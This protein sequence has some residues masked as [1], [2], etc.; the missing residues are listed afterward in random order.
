MQAGGVAG[1]IHHFIRF[2]GAGAT[3]AVIRQLHH[4]ICEL[5]GISPPKRGPP[6][7]QALQTIP[8]NSRG[9]ADD[10]R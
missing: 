3:K 10:E 7:Q 4:D 9:N 6:A 1:I 5:P 2:T 8:F